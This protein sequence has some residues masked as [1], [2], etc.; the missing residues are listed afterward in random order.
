[1]VAFKSNPYVSRKQGET[2]GCWRGDLLLG[3]VLLITLPWQQL[4]PVPLTPCNCMRKVILPCPGTCFLCTVSGCCS[5]SIHSPCWE[6]PCLDLSVLQ[7]SHHQCKCKETIKSILG[8]KTPPETFAA[9]RDAHPGSKFWANRKKWH[10]TKPVIKSW[11][12]L[13]QDIVTTK[14][15]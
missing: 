13:I 2:L 14:K 1:M 10:F 5:S 15:I 8:I 4:P 11:N 12:F 7:N 3:D 9:S 6:K